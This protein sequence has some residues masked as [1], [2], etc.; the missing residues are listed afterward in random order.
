MKTWTIMLT[1][2]FVLAA[3]PFVTAEESCSRASATQAMA[4]PDPAKKDSYIFFDVSE[5]EKLGEWTE[6][7]DARGLQTVACFA[8]SGFAK[9]GPDRQVRILG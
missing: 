9:Y 8:A 2:G 7:N 1:A 5:R 4:H 3:I 6:S